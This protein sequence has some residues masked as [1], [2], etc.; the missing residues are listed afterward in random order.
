MRLYNKMENEIRKLDNA[1]KI[2]KVKEQ[3]RQEIKEVLKAQ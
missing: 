1:E 3:Y 2:K